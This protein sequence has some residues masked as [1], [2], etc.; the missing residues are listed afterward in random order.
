MPKV[1]K[2]N[3]INMA[4][5]RVDKGQDGNNVATAPNIDAG[6]GTVMVGE[7]DAIVRRWRTM[8]VMA[9]AMMMAMSVPIT[10]YVWDDNGGKIVKVHINALPICHPS[11]STET[12]RWEV[13]NIW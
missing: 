12:I 6:V 13:T 11:S 9:M 4:S 8:A 5:I 1:C 2:C 7:D 3:T 10:R